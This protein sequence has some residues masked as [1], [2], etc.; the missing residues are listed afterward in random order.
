[1]PCNSFHAKRKLVLDINSTLGI[2]SAFTIR[3]LVPDQ[4]IH[5]NLHHIAPPAPD[6]RE[7]HF[8]YILPI[9]RID[10]VFELADL[11]FARAENKITGCDFVAKIFADLGNAKRQSPTSNI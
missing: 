5:I 1:M 3:Y 10:K 4:I 8:K 11:K 7:P 9:F 6:F 2:V